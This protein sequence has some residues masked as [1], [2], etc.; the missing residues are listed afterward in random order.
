MTDYI[1]KPHEGD[2]EELREFFH[3]STGLESVDGVRHLINIERTRGTRYFVAVTEDEKIIGMAGLWLDTSRA[4]TMQEPPQLIDVAVLPERKGTGLGRALVAKAMQETQAAGFDGLWLYT[5]GGSPDNL[6]F[7]LSMGFQLIA[8]VPG[9]FGPGTTK[10]VMRR[11]FT[12][13]ENLTDAASA[14]SS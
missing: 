14:V 4:I 5:N 9:W 3:L 1:I 13:G 2:L 12:P 10:A 8:A 6:R 11:D 7:Y